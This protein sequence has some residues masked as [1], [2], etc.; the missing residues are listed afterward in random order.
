VAASF[1]HVAATCLTSGCP[2]DPEMRERFGCDAPRPHAYAV[3]CWACD[4]KLPARNDD[5]PRRCGVCE[6]G[7]SGSQGIWFDRCPRT[8]VTPDLL[9]VVRLVNDVQF[10]LL[11][12]AG[13]ILDQSHWWHEV[14]RHVAPLIGKHERLEMKLRQKGRA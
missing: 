9:E 4:G 12:A 6:R 7:P 3:A 5:S 1:G 2:S 10:G 8:V 13:G 11:P 14:Y